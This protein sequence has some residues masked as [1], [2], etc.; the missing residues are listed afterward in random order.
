MEI[1]TMATDAPQTASPSLDTT[2]KEQTTAQPVSGTA[3]SARPG[4]IASAVEGSPSGTA[5]HA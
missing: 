2:A 5:R 3:P 1:L 4:R